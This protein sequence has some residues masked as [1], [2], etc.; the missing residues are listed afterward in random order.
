MEITTKYSIGDT[1]YH[2]MMNKVNEMEITSISIESDGKD[3]YKV[4]YSG[5][6]NYIAEADNLFPSKE[7]LLKNL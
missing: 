6:E 7:E 5:G 4:Y 1:V 2:M 3:N